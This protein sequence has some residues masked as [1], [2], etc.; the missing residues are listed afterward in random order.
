MNVN[1]WIIFSFEKYVM[2]KSMIMVNYAPFYLITD[3]DLYE[4]CYLHDFTYL[5]G[6]LVVMNNNLC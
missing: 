6:F 4:R 2:R 3:P 5:I 1:R